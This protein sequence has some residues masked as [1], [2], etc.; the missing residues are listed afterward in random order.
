MGLVSNSLVDNED[1]DIE[2][3]LLKALTENTRNVANKL[4]PGNTAHANR[5]Y[6]HLMLTQKIIITNRADPD[7]KD[8]SM[9]IKCYFDSLP[10]EDLSTIIYWDQKTLN[11]V[12][13]QILRQSYRDTTSYYHGMFRLLIDDENSP[14][15]TFNE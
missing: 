1:G 7:W 13:S 3:D 14:Y 5:L 8:S 10:T 11:N 4:S 6:H 15:R 9:F 12:D 2:T